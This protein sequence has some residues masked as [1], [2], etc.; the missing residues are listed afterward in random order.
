MHALICTLERGQN[1]KRTPN[2]RVAA[3]SERNLAFKLAGG[4]VWGT[5]NIHVVYWIIY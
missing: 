3:R 2:A 5:V 1:H 4:F